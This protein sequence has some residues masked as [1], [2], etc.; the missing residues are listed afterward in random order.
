MRR[1]LHHALAAAG[2]SLL[3]AGAVAG[4]LVPG[5]SASDTQART[6]PQVATPAPVLVVPSVTEAQLSRRL[7]RENRSA[8]RVA[9]AVDAAA[10]K[11]DRALAAQRAATTKRQAALAR[12]QADEEKKDK[13]EAKERD[14]AAAKARRLGYDPD[15]TSPKS[16]AR[17]MMKNS[18]GWGASEFRCYN[19]IIMNES[20]WDVHADNP[21]SSAYGIPQALPGSK[22]ASAGSDWRDN[23][24][25]QI[26][27]GLGYVEDRYGTPCS[28]WSFKS[29]HGWY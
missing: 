10:V 17:Q 19:N 27:W 2:I 16:I 3:T 21:T 20:V 13:A 26:K 14:A 9:P 7:E 15:T 6:A 1:L 29:A 12:K 4:A 23:P 28:A 11:R 24:A 18:Y 25:T 8:R 22:M 5:S